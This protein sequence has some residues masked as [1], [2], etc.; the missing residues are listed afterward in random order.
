MDKM[1]NSQKIETGIAKLIAET[2]KINQEVRWYPLIGIIAM[3]GAGIAAAKL[4]M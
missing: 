4:F 3:V 2:S 1:L